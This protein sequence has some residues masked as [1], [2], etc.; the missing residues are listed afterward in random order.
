MVI[1]NYHAIL[2]I[3]EE[4]Y[5]MQSYDIINASQDWERFIHVFNHN[6]IYS[7]YTIP[8]DKDLLKVNII[9]SSEKDTSFVMIGCDDTHEGIIHAEI[10]IREGSP[11][12]AI[13][14][15]VSTSNNLA[16]WL[17]EQAHIW[18]K[19][20]GIFRVYA[21]GW[22]PNPYSFILH[23]AE[24]YAW[25]GNYTAANAFRRLD[26]DIEHDVIVMFYDIPE[27]P[28]IN[29]AD[30]EGL[31]I[32]EQPE[33]GNDLMISGQ[34]T[35][36]TDLN[37]SGNCGYIYLK[38]ISSYFK[39]GIGQIWIWA[40][41]E[42]HGKGLGELLMTSAHKKLYNLGARKV[43]LTTNQ[44]LFRAVKFYE[45]IGYKPELIRGYTYSKEL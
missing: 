4:K 33:K 1:F 38:A 10:A 25:S 30:I 32:K 29:S 15:L 35:V 26:Y 9:P 24:T 37:N 31:T 5:G 20:R 14:L 3:S 39:K 40:D 45:K 41:S 12:G 34:I 22:Y 17:L 16:Q 2:V 23:G 44:G 19:E 42:L 11:A 43:I 36:S 7:P 21:Y 6:T 28:A 18:L 27:E 13:Y 8:V